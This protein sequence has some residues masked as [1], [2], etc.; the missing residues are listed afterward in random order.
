MLSLS[1]KT[2]ERIFPMPK[3]KWREQ[4]IRSIFYSLCTTT[5]WPVWCLIILSNSEDYRQNK[6]RYQN[7]YHD[8]GPNGAC[9]V[10]K[11]GHGTGRIYVQNTMW[12][13]YT[14]YLRSL[15][16]HIYIFFII[17]HTL[18]FKIDVVSL[19]NF[20]QNTKLLGGFFAVLFICCVC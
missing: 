11:F 2:N 14:V 5:E 6:N 3:K 17:K 7:M 18:R 8:I 20:I 12:Y 15:H 13:R 1:H 10:C 4:G 19:L 9:T 16:R